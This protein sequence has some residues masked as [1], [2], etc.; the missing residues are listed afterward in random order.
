MTN[1]QSEACTQIVSVYIRYV[2]ATKPTIFII[3][4]P[5]GL[6]SAFAWWDAN[7]N[8]WLHLAP[9]LNSASFQIIIDCEN[10]L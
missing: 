6:L 10:S 9:K 8:Y 7:N 4:A 5:I 1:I 2:E 3:I